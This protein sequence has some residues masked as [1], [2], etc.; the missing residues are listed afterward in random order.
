MA[1]FAFFDNRSDMEVKKTRHNMKE[2]F[3]PMITKLGI[4]IKDW[5]GRTWNGVQK[6]FGFAL[7]CRTTAR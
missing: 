5:F 4:E 7:S 3:I 6:F 2:D 1:Q